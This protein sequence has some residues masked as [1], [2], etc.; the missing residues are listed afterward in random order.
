[1]HNSEEMGNKYREKLYRRR[2]KFERERGIQSG[3]KEHC[4][5]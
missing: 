1:M 4:R 5:A 3:F 2:R